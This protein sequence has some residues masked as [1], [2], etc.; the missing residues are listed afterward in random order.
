M[1]GEFKESYFEDNREKFV[2][3]A[4]NGVRFVF[5]GYFDLARISEQ[6]AIDAL[7]ICE[8]QIKRQF[9]TEKARVTVEQMKGKLRELSELIEQKEKESR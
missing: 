4:N 8:D 3:A 1:R 7:E 6:K 5:G 9:A 2:A